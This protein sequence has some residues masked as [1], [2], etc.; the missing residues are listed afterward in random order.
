MTDHLRLSFTS[1]ARMPPSLAPAGVFVSLGIHLDSHANES[2]VGWQSAFVRQYKGA[3]RFAVNAQ[4][5]GIGEGT[6]LC[7]NCS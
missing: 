5:N 3:P 7:R 1:S 2:L 4:E 6:V